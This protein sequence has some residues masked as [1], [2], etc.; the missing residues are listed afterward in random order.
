MMDDL[1]PCPFCGGTSIVPAEG[2]FP[3]EI[4]LICD[5]CGAAGPQLALFDGAVLLRG[6]DE[7][8]AKAIELWNARPGWRI[9]CNPDCY[10]VG[11][12]TDCVHPKHCPEDRLCPRCNEVTEALPS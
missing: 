6:S 3:S 12:E 10:W 7:N 11:L 8:L 9:C 2:D 4:L 5:N 1:L